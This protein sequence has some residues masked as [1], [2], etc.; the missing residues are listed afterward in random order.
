MDPTDFIDIYNI[1]Y[2]SIQKDIRQE[3]CKNMNL[4]NYNI[5]IYP[6]F[7][8]INYVEEDNLDD[9]INIMDNKQD[10]NTISFKM[11]IYLNEILKSYNFDKAKI[12]NQL[13]LDLPR[14]SVYINDILIS[15]VD[16]FKELTCDFLMSD[17][18]INN[19]M[20]DL[21][22]ILAMLSNQSSYGF[23]YIFLYKLYC[24][25]QKNVF[26]TSESTGRYVK[27]NF[28]QNTNNISIS[29]EADFGVKNIEE[30]IKL[31]SINMALLININVNTFSQNGLLSWRFF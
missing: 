22:T 4:S 5:N 19:Q 17:I 13:E 10:N 28:D 18:K 6:D 25:N 23:P 9:Y 24:Q 20:Y 2:E 26:L 27:F 12:W 14:T 16:K 30:D 15:D 7:T 8:V 11:S 29:I 3:L 31:H 21:V 1:L